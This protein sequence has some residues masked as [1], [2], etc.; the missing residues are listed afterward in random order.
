MAGDGSLRRKLPEDPADA[1]KALKRYRPYGRMIISAFDKGARFAETAPLDAEEKEDGTFA[2]SALLYEEGAELSARLLVALW[3]ISVISLR[4][5]EFF[6]KKQR[7]KELKA[8]PLK[9]LQASVG[10]NEK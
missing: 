10:S 5:M 2:F 6:E 8:N 4:V 7:E 9:A 1:D 3:L